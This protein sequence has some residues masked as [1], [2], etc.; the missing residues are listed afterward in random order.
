MAN[1]NAS[2]PYMVP[3]S[4][5]GIWE[6]V[7]RF[8]ELLFT[9]VK[10]VL[11]VFARIMGDGP[12]GMFIVVVLCF[13]IWLVRMGA[14]SRSVSAYG[15][16]MRTM[17]LWGFGASM[18]ILT[19]SGLEATVLPLLVTLLHLTFGSIGVAETGFVRFFQAMQNP[20]AKKLFTAGLNSTV[21]NASILPLSRLAVFWLAKK[22]GR[23]NLSPWFA[24]V[25]GALLAISLLFTFYFLLSGI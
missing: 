16:G 21:Q 25:T 24:A 5:Q 2:E 12:V 19:I 11:S 1:T 17:G 6:S 20:H 13:C 8:A 7:Q 18:L 3:I 23:T 14:S 4:P 22:A 9:L 10:P 15:E